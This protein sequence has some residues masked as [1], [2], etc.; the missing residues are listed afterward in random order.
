MS[1]RSKK[2]DDIVIRPA[3]SWWLSDWRA[4][5]EYRGLMW[6]FI[7]RDFRVRYKQTFLGIFW[8]IF[9][10]LSMTIVFSLVFG[11]LFE[12]PT[13]ND[14]PYAVFVCAG[15]VP[16]VFFS[17]AVARSSESLLSAAGMI[18][19]VY[20]PRIILPLSAIGGCLVDLGVSL[21]VLVMVMLYF[22]VPI[23][24]NILWLPLWLFCLLIAALGVGTL[25]SSLVALFRDFRYATPFMLQMMLFLTPVIY[26]V[27]LLPEA[28]RWVMYVNPAAG[29]VENFRGAVLGG[30]KPYAIAPDSG[31]S[32]LISCCILVLAISVFARMQKKIVDLI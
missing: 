17:S 28:W 25:L 32:V 31:L 6:A 11:L 8:A 15:L 7:Q 12:Q 24:I 2:R 21:A 9:Q 27:T 18:S 22:G 3:S 19:K 29:A 1:S 13:D 14:L 10:P 30:V 16:W 5:W 23:D 4:V 26:P 20:F